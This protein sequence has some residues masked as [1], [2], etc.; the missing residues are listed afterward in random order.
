MT[1]RTRWI[2]F[3]V[4][5]VICLGAG[6]LGAIETT[7]EIDG[8]YKTIVKPTWNPLNYVFGPVFTTLFAMMAI[9]AWLVWQ[10]AGFRAANLRL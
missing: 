4:F 3:A 8:W 5:L 2:G 9:A 1:E 6:G 10:P 7:P